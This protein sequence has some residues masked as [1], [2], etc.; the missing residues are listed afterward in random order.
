MTRWVLLTAT[1]DQ[2]QVAALAAHPEVGHSSAGADLPGSVGGPGAVWDLVT[3]ADPRSLP[4]VPADAE[5]VPLVT[6]AQQDVPFDGPRIKRTLLL[7]VADGT[8]D[9]VVRRFEQDTIA[10]P[11]HISTIRAWALSRVDTSLADASTRWTHVWEQE[12]VDADGLNGEYLLHPYHWTYVDNWFDPESPRHIVEPAIAHL[13]RL[14]EGPVL[15]AQ[16][17]ASSTGRPN[18]SRP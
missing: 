7:T 6:I 14:A 2:E 8:P 1:V 11:D 10:M 16:M 13:Y 9:E 17:S 12:F 18:A 5:A 4:G 15:L 3:D